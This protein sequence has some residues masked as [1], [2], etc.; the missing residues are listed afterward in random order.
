[1]RTILPLLFVLALGTSAMMW[2]MSGFAGVYGSGTPGELGSADAIN[3]SASNSSV[4]AFSADAGPNEGGNILGLIFSGHGRV[5]SLA[6]F[7]AFLPAELHTLGMP[8]WG[9]F[10]LGNAGR[11]FLGIGVFQFATNRLWQ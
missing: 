9:A 3:E 6:G 11:I 8:W 10:P 7:I 2:G 5:V 1:M 4:G